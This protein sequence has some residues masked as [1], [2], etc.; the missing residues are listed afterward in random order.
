ML[1]RDCRGA[2]AIDSVSVTRPTLATA[3]RC[4]CLGRLSVLACLAASFGT[5]LYR[6][7]LVL[8]IALL[9]TVEVAQLADGLAVSLERVDE[10]ARGWMIS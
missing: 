4:V 5:G 8:C 10:I 3:A 2:V 6:V 7:V 9:L 1:A